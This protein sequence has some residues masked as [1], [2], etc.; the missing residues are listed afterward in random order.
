M[1]IARARLSTAPRSDA[2]ATRSCGRSGTKVIYVGSQ[3]MSG[4]HEHHEVTILLVEDEALVRELQ[5][6][7]LADAGYHVVEAANADVAMCVL[8]AEPERIQVLFTDVDMPGSMDG[9]RL[10]QVAHERWPHL[11]LLVTSGKIRP[12]DRDLPDHGR[13][14]PK[15]HRSA[16]LTALVAEVVATPNHYC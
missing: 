8:E 4:L 15:P 1:L 3:S 10:A 7:V 16:A 2:G 6:E 5:A 14:L 9:I 13:F 12:A 11:K